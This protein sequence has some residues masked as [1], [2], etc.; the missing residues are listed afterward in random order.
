LPFDLPLALVFVPVLA[1]AWTEAA[2]EV[3]LE[4]EEGG[5]VAD[6]GFSAVGLGAEEEEGVVPLDCVESKLMTDD[7]AVE[8]TA[9]ALVVEALA[10][11]ALEAGAAAAGSGH[12]LS[13]IFDMEEI[14]P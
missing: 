2:E 4:D 7:D 9:E 10:V 13:S 14:S 11:E 5:A 3:A 12:P 1:G 8:A 6:A